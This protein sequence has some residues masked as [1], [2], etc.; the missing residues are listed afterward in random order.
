MKQTSKFLKTIFFTS[1]AVCVVL[2]LLGEFG[3]GVFK[4]WQISPVTD[5]Y[6]T[7]ALELITLFNIPFALRLFKFNKIRARL[8]DQREKALILWGTLRLLLLCVP[9]ILSTCLYSFTDKATFFY[10]AVILFLCLFFVYPS[11][12]RCEAE[13]TPLDKQ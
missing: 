2:I 10:L 5:F 4:K 9:M 12:A 3:G 11:M 7:A 13:V 6:L 1:V 8:C